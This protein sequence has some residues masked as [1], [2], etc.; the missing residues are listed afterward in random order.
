MDLVNQISFHRAEHSK[1]VRGPGGLNCPC[2]RVSSKAK[3][4]RINA[5]ALRRAAKIAVRLTHG[6]D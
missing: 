3:S 1:A 6:E 4:K 5:R 2:C